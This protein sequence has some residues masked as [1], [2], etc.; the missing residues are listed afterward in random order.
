M[1]VIPAT[2]T[3]ITTLYGHVV[4][5]VWPL[6]TNADT[7]AAVEMGANADR[8]VHAFGTFGSATVALQGSNEA[9]LDPALVTSYVAMHDPQGVAIGLTTAGIEEVAEISH[10]IKP[11]LTGGGGTQSV[12]V[13]LLCRGVL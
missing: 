13:A 6:V 7:C 4:S 10:W 5:Y 9:T 11:V 12:T 3:T 2:I 8:S 1:A